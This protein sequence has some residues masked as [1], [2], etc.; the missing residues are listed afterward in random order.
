MAMILRAGT[1]SVPSSAIGKVMSPPADASSAGG[2]ESTGAGTTDGRATVVGD[3]DQGILT[4]PSQKIAPSVRYGVSA[5]RTRPATPARI[6]ESVSEDNGVAWSARPGFT[7]A[8][9]IPCVRFSTAVLKLRCNRLL[10]RDLTVG[11]SCRRR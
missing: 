7:L 5:M 9:E 8:H 11:T 4:A 2:D 10:G 3:L 6:S 1:P